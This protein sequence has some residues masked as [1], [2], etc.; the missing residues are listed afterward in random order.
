M[1]LIGEG[2]LNSFNYDEK[3]WKDIKKGYTHFAENDIGIA[4]I[5]PCFEN[6][7]SVI[8]NSLKNGFGAGTTELHIVRTIGNQIDK[9]FL[10]W[11]F[12]SEYFIKSGKKNFTGTAGQKRINKKFVENFLIP[13]P[14]LNEQISIIKKIEEVLPLIED[15]GK[16]YE[17][18]DKLNEDFPDKIKSSILQ[19]A[20]EG[21]LVPQDENDEPALGLLEK[22]K[23]EKEQLIKDKKIRVNKKESFIF[24]E[25][26]HYYEKIGDENP[27]CI[28]DEI[29]FEIPETW[30]WCRLNVV[31]NIY[32]GNSISKAK[33][34]AEFTGLKEGHNYIATKD[35]GFDNSINYENGV[36][37]PKNLDKFRI[38]PKNSVLLCIEG[39]SAGRKIAMTKED[40]CFGNKLCCFNNFGINNSFLFYYLQSESFKKVFKSEKTGIIGGVGIGKIRN[41][42]IPIP[43]LNEQ[44]KIVE[45]LNNLFYSI[46]KVI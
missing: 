7:K 46:N 43:P 21:N 30:A 36:K 17:S 5:T 15:Y 8:F 25:N 29:P 24:K 19:E 13:I 44:K 32:T 42:L 20:I 18:L 27:V 11:I 6:R 33:K 23:K 9:K 12:K 39:G 1:N 38:A 35:V 3:Y 40:V 22:I 28:D 10:L 4:K 16:L 26:N 31:E 2:Y 37:I 45:K 41:L 34:E 14:P